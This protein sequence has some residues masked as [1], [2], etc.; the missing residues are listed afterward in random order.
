[1]RH[2]LHFRY[3]SRSSLLKMQQQEV[4]SA[5]ISEDDRDCVSI[6][7]LGESVRRRRVTSAVWQCKSWTMKGWSSSGKFDGD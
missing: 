5:R 2:S 7:F 4:Q 3:C 6:P 1:M